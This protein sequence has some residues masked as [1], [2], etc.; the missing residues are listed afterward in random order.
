MGVQLQQSGKRL[1]SFSLKCFTEDSSSCFPGILSPGYDVRP[2][3]FLIPF[4]P[5]LDSDD[6]NKEPKDNIQLLNLALL[7]DGSPTL[8]PSFHELCWLDL[9]DCESLSSLPID[10]FK[11]KSLRRL[12]LSCCFNLEKFPEIE[13]TMES[14][15]VL[16]LNE[17]AIKEL[18]SSLNRLVNLEELSLY[19]CQ[20]LE[21]IPSSI[22]SLSKLSKLN[23]TFCESL[24]SFPSSI[25]KLKLTKLDLHGCSML[26]IFPEIL[27]PAET[28]VHINLTRTAIKEL[29]S[30]LEY[31]VRLQT[32]C[33][34]LC[35]ELVSLPNS[36]VNLNHLSELDCSGC[37]SIVNLPECIAHL[38]SLKSLNL[39]DCKRLECIP[40]LPPSLNKLLADDCPFVGGMI[41]NSTKKR[42]RTWL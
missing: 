14:L 16:I 13:A 24:E 6:L 31:L 33:L 20:K 5:F 15:E 34:N 12:Y 8:F 37:C 2:Q 25:F 39:S 7:R 11:M 10:L 36:I 9:S 21:T 40:Q 23:L 30:S 42:T 1:R 3:K 26:K 35:T 41:P 17:T 32:L 22:G 4:D 29:P 27:E 19:N 28:F 18:P 38:S